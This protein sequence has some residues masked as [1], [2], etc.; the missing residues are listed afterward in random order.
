MPPK[1]PQEE[2]MSGEVM[3]TLGRIEGLLQNF[4]DNQKAAAAAHAA[5]E[6][7]VGSLEKADGIRQILLERVEELEGK[8]DALT[9]RITYIL[10]AGGVI[11]LLLNLFSDVIISKF[12]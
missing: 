7:R 2:A 8:V 5:L 1:Q 4:S 11:L 3:R 9:S 10:G 12:G 6:T